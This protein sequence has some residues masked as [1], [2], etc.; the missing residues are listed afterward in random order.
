MVV[1]MGHSVDLLACMRLISYDSHRMR[2]TREIRLFPC[3]LEV[4]VLLAEHSR[5][6][7]LPPSHPYK[8]VKCQPPAKT[9]S[10]HHDG[11]NLYDLDVNQHCLLKIS[12]PFSYTPILWVFSPERSL[13][14]P[15][16]PFSSLPSLLLHSGFLM[17]PRRFAGSILEGG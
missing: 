8:L 15:V 10:S 7:S 16:P 14:S 11:I 17:V 12:L 9:R 2:R 3:A 5:L 13:L 1:H 4:H 6:P